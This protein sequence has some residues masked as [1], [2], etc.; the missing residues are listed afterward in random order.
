MAINRGYK[1][2]NPLDLNKNKII[3]IGFPL[4]LDSVVKGTKNTK[5]QIK[6]NL[7]NILLTEKGERINEP[8][9]G[10]GLRQLLFEPNIDLVGL[11]N[12]IHDQINFYIPEITLVDVDSNFVDSEHII[13]LTVS[14]RF[15]FTGETD[16]IQLNFK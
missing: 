5:E 8:N 1:R 6:S 15:N 12:T 3:G 9:F 2:V 4:S 14:Y 16:S 13:Y 11:K 7:I 10:V